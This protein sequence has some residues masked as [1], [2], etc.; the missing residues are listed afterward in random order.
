MSH[1]SSSIFSLPSSEKIF[2]SLHS[3]LCYFF[4]LTMSS[5]NEISAEASKRICTHMNEDHG[6]TVYA[7]AAHELTKAKNAKLQQPGWHMTDARMQ[8]VTMTSCRLQVFVCSGDM[9]EMISVDY[10]FNPPLSSS[11]QIRPRLIA[12][13]HQVMTPQISWLITKPVAL[14]LVLISVAMAHGIFVLGIPQFTQVLQDLD[15]G[16]GLNLVSTLFGSSAILVWMLQGIFWF[17]VVAHIVEGLYAVYHCRTTLKLGLK[18]QVLWFVLLFLAGYPIMKEFQ[19]LVSA[20]AA[21]RKLKEDEQ[22]QS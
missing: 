4:V 21:R 7:M 9:C 22:K 12:I 16:L 2:K 15:E 1:Q 20:A 19:V 10:P 14:V 13:H 5:P 17:T 8:R 6:V 18:A 11:S 3:V